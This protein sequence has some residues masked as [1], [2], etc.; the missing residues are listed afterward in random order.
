MRE[1]GKTLPDAPGQ[2]QRGLEVIEFAS[3]KSFILKPSGR[4][5]SPSWLTA[6]CEEGVRFHPRYKRIMQRW[7]D[8]GSK[9]P[10]FVMP[11]NWRSIIP[12]LT[13]W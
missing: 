13:L 12:G 5:A 3:G 4:A 9:G 6:G 11:V 2:V 8:G 10:E 1:Y 7:P